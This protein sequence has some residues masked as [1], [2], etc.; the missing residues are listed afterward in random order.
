MKNITKLIILILFI[1]IPILISSN[2][3]DKD[4]I[5]CEDSSS[6][7]IKNLFKNNTIR[8]D[9]SYD[10]KNTM[11]KIE[12]NIVR[13]SDINKLEWEKRDTSRNYLIFI[14]IVF[15]LGFLFLGVSKFFKKERFSKKVIIFILLSF[16]IPF[17][18]SA[19]F[20][21][22]L[23]KGPHANI[24]N[25]SGSDYHFINETIEKREDI[26]KE[27]ESG[28][29]EGDAYFN[30]YSNNYGWA[31]CDDK[32]RPYGTLTLRNA[33]FHYEKDEAS[34]SGTMTE[35]DYQ[36]FIIY[37]EKGEMEEGFS[38]YWISFLI[39]GFGF[40]FF[41]IYYFSFQKKDLLLANSQVATIFGMIGFLIL[42]PFAVLIC[43][44]AP[45]T[46]CVLTLFIIMIFLILL[47]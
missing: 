20:F 11:L 33:S 40:L 4:N 44:M 15:M 43:F 25:S 17:I 22:L 35:T 9:I 39:G 19:I 12:D 23:P 42:H 5:I 26:S 1:L 6:L 3:T 32:I 31:I 47:I 37:G 13:N 27:Q 21:G 29:F 14:P 30:G 18:I 16:L 38:I 45:T 8:N 36:K 28:Y 7:L 2:Y 46:G 34:W 24:V 41:S 10:S